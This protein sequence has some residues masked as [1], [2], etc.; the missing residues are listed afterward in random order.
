MDES[1]KQIVLKSVL[2][3][4]GVDKYNRLISSVDETTRRGSFRYWQN[5]LFAKLHEQIGL[6]INTVDDYVA[7]FRN[8]ASATKDITFEE[9][10]TDPN[11]YYYTEPVA[12]PNEWFVR[13][14]EDSAAFRENVT[15]GFSRE[16][17]KNGDL[18]SLGESLGHLIAILP[19]NR[20]I[21]LYQ[22]IRN[23]SPHRESEFR[24]TFERILGKR[25]SDFP[26]A[27]TNEEL[28]GMLGGD[29]AREVGIVQPKM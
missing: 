26:P 9:F 5:D 11:R 25:I 19:T 12:I 2:K 24:P 20:I 28:V 21:E 4:F 3:L 10:L 29:V 8:A 13:A 18:D 7:I 17:R 22:A 16:A 27:F 14:W 1:S 23:E 6:A 15:Y